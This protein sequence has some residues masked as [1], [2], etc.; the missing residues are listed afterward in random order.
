ML[1][2]L[3]LV[4]VFVVRVDSS[5]RFDFFL[6]AIFRHKIVN[7]TL[8]TISLDYWILLIH[9]RQ[10]YPYKLCDSSYS[11]SVSDLFR[12]FRP[13]CLLSSIDKQMIRKDIFLNP[14]TITPIL[15][16]LT[17]IVLRLAAKMWSVSQILVRPQWTWLLT[18]ETVSYSSRRDRYASSSSVSV[19][20]SITRF[21]YPCSNKM[22]WDSSLEMSRS[23]PDSNLNCKRL[24][25][26]FWTFVGKENIRKRIWQ[27]QRS[28]RETSW[29]H[30]SN[31][32]MTQWDE[33][34]SNDVVLC[35]TNLDNICIWTRKEIVSVGR[36][37]I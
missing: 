15:S 6:S 12:K 16:N 32:Q 10:I 21:T 3:F 37:D 20:F 5:N 24:D 11:F 28:G 22:T 2:I 7:F 31:A 35:V 1:I 34:Q 14:L 4:F 17:I 36:H 23:S 9:R 8:Q 25:P 27:F 29:D 26:R 13:L 30:F 18:I 33:I 19:V